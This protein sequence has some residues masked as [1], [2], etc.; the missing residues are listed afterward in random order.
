MEDFA[1]RGDLIDSDR[2]EKLM[3]RSDLRG[4]L[5]LVL[6]LVLLIATGVAVF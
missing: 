4:G 2:L 5:Q 3:E 1:P 6:H